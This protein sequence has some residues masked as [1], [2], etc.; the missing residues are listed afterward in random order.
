METSNAIFQH[1]HIGILIVSTDGTIELANAFANS[2]FGYDENELV[3]NKI[4]MLIPNSTRTSHVEDRLKYAEN[5][6]PR[7]MGVGRDLNGLRKNGEIFPVEISLCSYSINNEKKLVSFINDI[8]IRKKTENELKRLTTELELKVK[9]RTLEL[10]QA[11]VELSITNENLKERETEVKMALENEKEINEMKSRFVSMASHE[12]RTPL[13]GI[14]SSATLLDKYQAQEDA[15]KRDKHI[16]R[17]KKSVKNLTSIL[18]DFLSLDKLEEGVTTVTPSEFN[19]DSLIDEIVYDSQELLEGQKVEYIS[20]CSKEI[21]LFQDADMLRNI[22]INLISNAIKYS[23]KDTKITIETVSTDDYFTIKIKDQGIG[24][25]DIEKKHLF[26]RFFRAENALT[27]NGTGL[28]LN[29][30]KR[31]LDLMQ[32][33]ISFTSELN[34][35]TTFEITLPLRL[36]I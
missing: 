23:M 27:I 32:G 22:F 6:I 13:A 8:S 24:I 19:I 2:I 25:P 36:T 9:E 12:F 16:A 26:G 28:G 33:E 5:P 29:I 34:I 1:A 18:T 11:L 21:E 17:I 15:L 30:V 31:Y 14:L 20:N 3:G 35:G 4:E 7:S 10:S